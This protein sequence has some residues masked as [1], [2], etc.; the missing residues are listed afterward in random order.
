M[1]QTGWFVWTRLRFGSGFAGIHFR[2]SRAQTS[3]RRQAA[4]SLSSGGENE[5]TVQ[6]RPGQQ[7]NRITEDPSYP[8]W[9][10][11]PSPNTPAFKKSNIVSSV[12]NLV[13]V[14]VNSS[15]FYLSG[16]TQQGGHWL[17]WLALSLTL[18]RFAVCVQTLLLDIRYKV[19]PEPCAQ[20]LDVSTELTCGADKSLTVRTLRRVWTVNLKVNSPRGL[21]QTVFGTFPVICAPF[22]TVYIPKWPQ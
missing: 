12:W 7:F 14:E 8:C 17:P 21:T 20:A 11:C 5:C 6:F 3:T 16:W 15:S 22:I 2:Q 13:K 19:S 1:G 10:C 18:D 9:G 4:I